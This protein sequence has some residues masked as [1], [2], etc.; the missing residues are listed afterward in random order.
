MG[1]LLRTPRIHTQSHKI[2]SLLW[3]C[4]KQA[5]FTRTNHSTGSTKLAQYTASPKD[6][7][8]HKTRINDIPRIGDYFNIHRLLYFSNIQLE[9]VSQSIQQDTKA[10]YC[11]FIDRLKRSQE[12]APPHQPFRQQGHHRNGD[13]AAR[14]SHI[15]C[16][17]CVHFIASQ[18][19]LKCALLPFALISN[20][21]IRK[22]TF[23]PTQ[24]GRQSGTEGIMDRPIR[25]PAHGF[26]LGPH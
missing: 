10:R 13:Q 8:G 1:I 26:I 9:R 16:S 11:Q 17:I 14:R 24:F 23:Q 15:L 19:V 6:K 25:K 7:N 2:V 21:M 3:S 20:H 5:S 12:K 4:S 22:E 18:C